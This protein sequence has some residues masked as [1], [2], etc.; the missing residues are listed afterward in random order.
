MIACAPTALLG[1]PHKALLWLQDRSVVANELAAQQ[2][3]NSRAQRDVER[4]KNREQ[5][6]AKVPAKGPNSVLHTEGD[7][8]EQCL[9]NLSVLS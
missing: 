5:L 7:L 3:L 1:R 8:T 2:D 6:L 9:Q 4:F